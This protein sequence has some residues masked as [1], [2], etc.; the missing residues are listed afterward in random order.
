M[1]SIKV[2]KHCGTSENLIVTKNGIIWRI[3]VDCKSK[4]S[5]NI[6]IGRHHSPKTKLKMSTTYKLLHPRIDKILTCKYCKTSNADDFIRKG[7]KRTGKTVCTK[8]LCDRQT[9]DKSSLFNTHLSD[10]TKLKISESGK[11]R[12]VSLETRIK[13]SIANKFSVEYYRE[14]YPFFCEVEEIR[15]APPKIGKAGIQVR[16]KKC[17]N[18][19][20][21]S[22]HILF[23]RINALEKGNGGGCY[24]YC[25]DE[26][27][28]SC[29]IFGY[30]PTKSTT[31]TSKIDSYEYQVWR[32]EVLIRQLKEENICFNHCEKCNSEINLHVHHEH[33]VKTHPHMALDPDNGIILCRECHY[34]F[35]HLGDCSTASLA[36]KI[37]S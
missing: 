34:R 26:C 24:F 1:I 21:P 12:Y 36:N 32:N 8:C 23:S 22:S 3:C 29:P 14:K 30:Q 4:I 9:G 15:E 13:N 6:Q 5:K 35:G 25:S 37:C 20:T 11:G 19:F 7:G 18:W 27:K 10:E 33:P 17:N 28:D 16:C 2:C 31:E